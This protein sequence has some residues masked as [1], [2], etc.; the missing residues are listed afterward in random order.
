MSRFASTPQPP[1]F[2][3]IF[4][5]QRRD[6]SDDKYGATAEALV[7]RFHQLPGCLGVE[8]A[9]SPDGF[10]VTV[11]YFADEDSIR[12]WKEDPEHLKAQHLGRTTWYSHY[13]VRFA[14]V[15]REYSGPE[16]R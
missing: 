15:G 4:T 7:H 13:D 14:R 2:A 1:Y 9:E 10:A 12:A 16:G 5:S 11:A 3:A 8:S 6:T